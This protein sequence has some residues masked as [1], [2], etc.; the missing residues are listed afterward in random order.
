M[1][2][3]MIVPGRNGNGWAQEGY[4]QIVHAWNHD[5]WPTRGYYQLVPIVC[6]TRGGK[7]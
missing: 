6:T 7:R 1:P 3:T 4:Q 5:L 2:L